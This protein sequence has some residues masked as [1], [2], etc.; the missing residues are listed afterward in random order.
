M[1]ARSN[2]ALHTPHSTLHTPLP[3]LHTPLPTLFALLLLLFTTAA[4]AQDK[5]SDSAVQFN[6]FGSFG[7][8]HNGIR[9][10]FASG[11]WNLSGSYGYRNFDGYREHSNEYAHRFL[12]SS[13]ATPTP[14]TRVTV[15][16]SYIDE[17]RK[18]PGSLTK[19]EFA[20]TPFA[21]DPRAVARDEKRAMRSSALEVGY[22]A[23]FGRDRNQKFALKG[24]GNIDNLLKTTREFKIISRYIL[25]AEGLYANTHALAGLKN[26]VTAG[27]SVGLQPER[28]EE[29]ENFSGQKS[30]QLEQIET[31][32]MGSYSVYASDELQLFPDRSFLTL[33]ARYD[34]ITYHVAETTLPARSDVRDY[35][36]FTPG[37]ALTFGVGPGIDARIAFTVD[38]RPP[39]DRELE[40]PDPAF[41]YNH[42]LEG[43]VTGT[44]E[45][46]FTGDVMLRDSGQ[47]F[48][49]IRF[50]AK[51]GRLRISQ[52][53]VPY[54]IYGDDYYR[55]A[56]KTTGFEGG[57]EADLRIVE[58][59]EFTA[60]WKFTG[61]TY[62]DYT[63]NCYEA[64]STGN[65]VVVYHDFAGKTMP[66]RPDN[67]FYTSLDF[68]Y[69]AGSHV[70][71]KAGADY[72]YSDGFWVDDLNSE[73]TAGFSLVGLRAGIGLRFGGFFADVEAGTEN[74]FDETYAAYATVN[75]ADR[76][77]Y[78]AGAPRG[79]YGVVNIGYKISPL[80]R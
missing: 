5:P 45:A 80:S 43:Q 48:N 59:L 26:T 3:T 38:F 22:Q 57:I 52:A 13:V 42:T 32:R 11:P 49:R 18:S 62:K 21:A 70:I 4:S 46:G 12:F 30:D 31:E 55:N 64:D 63:A 10:G 8:F 69:K 37:A 24:A 39:Q 54:E 7:L 51:A 47:V 66:D 20:A 76:R 77:F 36:A 53:I 25:G 56:T 17:L 19:T 15:G 71:L 1:S 74:L 72:R 73:K 2:S 41:L 6:R 33:T 34:H 23:L 79:F 61:L 14:D 44:F 40:S 28:K 68:K 75:S 58:G 65:I 78:N 60:G 27:G 50:S 9:G 35:H 29:Y 16:F 67:I